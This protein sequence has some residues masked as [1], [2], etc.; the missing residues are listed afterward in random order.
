MES[1]THVEGE[2]YTTSTVTTSKLACDATLHAHDS[3]CYNAD[4]E[5]TCTET[6]YVHTH[7]GDCYDEDGN[8]VCPLQ[9]IKAHTHTSDCYDGDTLTCGQKEIIV[10]SH[11]D[12]CYS[13]GSSTCEKA[14]VVEH[15]HSD[16]C[17]AETEEQETLLTCELAEH[18]HDETCENSASTE[19]AEEE[20]ADEE[21]AAD[22]AEDSDEA[23]VL[24]NTDEDYSSLWSDMSDDEFVAWVTGGEHNDYIQEIYQAENTETFEVFYARVEA[25]EDE[26]SQAQVI[27]YMSELLLDDGVAMYADG[28]STTWIEL[29]VGNVW[30]LATADDTKYMISSGT[31]DCYVTGKNDGHSPI[32]GSDGYYVNR[33]ALLSGNYRLTD[34]FSIGDVK[35][36]EDGNTKVYFIQVAG[37]VTID[38]NGHVLQGTGG[39]CVSRLM[40][41]LLLTAERVLL[42]V[43]MSINMQIVESMLPTALRL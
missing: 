40:A 34:N 33:I 7:S 29:N 6:S 15:V 10:H 8:L 14:A 5:L 27:D 23:V 42:V 35:T 28:D 43:S 19:A 12:A 41:A 24:A 18:T 13:D 3:S 25:I 30:S 2:C 36:G 4:G 39:Y 16:S 38:L 22:E 9:E 21:E 20:D 11:T 17:Y 26:D 1:H 31:G 32:I 37:N